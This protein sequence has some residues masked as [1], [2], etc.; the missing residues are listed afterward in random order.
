MTRRAR[1]FTH[2]DAPTIDAETGTASKSARKRQM[3]ALQNLGDRL[4]ALKP[5]QWSALALPE[6]LIEALG[7]LARLKSHEARRRQMQ[8][9]GKLMR[10][11]DPGPI[12]AQLERWDAGSRAGKAA[13]RAAEHW[14]ARLLETPEA[15]T[16][17]RRLKPGLDAAMLVELVSA[18]RRRAERQDAAAMQASRQLFR[19]LH[20]SFLNP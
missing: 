17:L 6:S 3:H 2:T 8:Y 16:E 9:I 12:E 10:E 5:E 1:S 19:Y 18:A 4:A 15:I 13:F 11:V 14:R 20:E 7:E